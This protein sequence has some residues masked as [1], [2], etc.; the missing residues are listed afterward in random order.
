[1][2]KENLVSLSISENELAE[3]RKAIEILQRTLLPYLL[4]LT[5]DEK[6]SMAK[7][8]DKTVAF[9]TKATEHAEAQPKLVPAFIEVAELRKDLEAIE[10][11]RPFFNSLN[12]L[13][14]GLDDTMTVAGSEAYTS[15][16]AF[17]Q[18][19]KMGAKLNVSGAQ[20]IYN[21]LQ[22]RFPSKTRKKA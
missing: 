6:E 14:K 5:K 17:Y 3:I 15:A 2:N 16:L 13:S 7:M 10:I 18:S 22:V 20:E 9:V 4:E 8:G 1:M 19:V 21:D 12:Q 11:L